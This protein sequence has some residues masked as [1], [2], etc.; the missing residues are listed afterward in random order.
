MILSQAGAGAVL[1]HGDLKGMQAKLRKLYE[2]VGTQ[3]VSG[4]LEAYS[5]KTGSKQVAELLEKAV[6][7]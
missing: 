5:R 7:I 1:G 2:S 6:G 4:S 3:Q